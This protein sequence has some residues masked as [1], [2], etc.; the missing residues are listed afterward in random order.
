MHTR[1]RYRVLDGDRLSD[2]AARLG[3]S[4][5]DVLASNPAKPTMV[6]PSGERVFQ[7]LSAGEELDLPQTLGVAPVAIGLAVSTGAAAI[8]EATRTLYRSEAG[9]VDVCEAIYGGSW[10]YSKDKCIGPSGQELDSTL[11]GLC[12]NLGA[13]YDASADGCVCPPQGCTQM[14]PF[15]QDR[16]PELTAEN[17]QL[18]P[19]G[20]KRTDEPRGGG[21]GMPAPP[22]PGEP[23]T[24]SNIWP[25]VLATSAVVVVGVGAAAVSVKLIVDAIERAREPKGRARNPAPRVMNIEQYAKM[26]NGK[27]SLDV[28]AHIHA[29]L[30]SAPRTKTYKRFFDKKLAE[31]QDARDKT[32]AEY[33]AAIE[34]GEIVPPARRSLEENAERDDEAGAAARRVLERRAARLAGK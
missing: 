34:R 12:N 4:H 21:D 32:K 20:T 2:I 27:T 24:N 5:L 10:S 18:P 22:E 16:Y 14:A 9:G 25:I 29:G 6:L 11:P 15:I 17:Q 31:L 13:V 7:S 23:K 1:F 30:R 19:F 28:Q 33:D 26:T 3:V 8:I